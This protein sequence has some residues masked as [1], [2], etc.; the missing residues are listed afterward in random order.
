MKYYI[1]NHDSIAGELSPTLNNIKRL[2]CSCYHRHTNYIELIEENEDGN[3]EVLAHLRGLVH[4]DIY[5]NPDVR[6]GEEEDAIKEFWENDFDSSILG[7]LSTL[8]VTTL[9]KK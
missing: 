8:F 1:T 4:D 3:K 6:C 2:Y 7:F 5:G 9:P